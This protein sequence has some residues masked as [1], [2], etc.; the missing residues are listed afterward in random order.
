MTETVAKAVAFSAAWNSGFTEMG[1]MYAIAFQQG[2][3]TVQHIATLKGVMACLVEIY[4][5][6][7]ANKLLVP[8]EELSP[9]LKVE[10]KGMALPFREHLSQNEMVRLCKAIWVLNSIL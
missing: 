7:V 5:V 4:H 3:L 6:H 10:L 8:I 1:K 9:E 2:R